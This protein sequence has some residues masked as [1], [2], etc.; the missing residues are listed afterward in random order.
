MDAISSRLLAVLLHIRLECRLVQEEGFKGRFQFDW[1][2][3]LIVNV[4][5]ICDV[6]LFAIRCFPLLFFNGMY[7]PFRWEIAEICIDTRFLEMTTFFIYQTNYSNFFAS[8]CRLWLQRRNFS[9]IVTSL[10][11]E[12]TTWASIPIQVIH[13]KCADIN[14]GKLIYGREFLSSYYWQ[15]C[16]E[17]DDIIYL[18]SVA[19]QLPADED[20]LIYRREF[21][22]SY[23]WQHCCEIDDNIYLESVAHQLPTDEDK[24]IYRR[25]F[26]SSYYWPHCWSRWYLESVL[27]TACPRT[28]TNS[29]TEDN[30]WVLTTGNTA[31]EGD[32]L[33]QLL[34]GCPRMT[35]YTAM[36]FR[37]GLG[38]W[39]RFTRIVAR[40][41]SHRAIIR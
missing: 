30:F 36:I 27:L 3:R 31:V 1:P 34:T 28:K 19:H 40:L 2:R 5:I 13:V 25:E 23:Y 32:I 22:G 24:L 6:P 38:G 4:S 8:I 17:K 7:M 10:L 41:G 14:W 35:T 21:L 33:N 18:E 12:Y 9:S 16:C 37:S 11:N 26:L 15:H 29:F 20:K 39:S